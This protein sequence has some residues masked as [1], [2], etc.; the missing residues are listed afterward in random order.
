LTSQ[1]AVLPRILGIAF[2]RLDA[3]VQRLHGAGAA[4]YRGSASVEQGESWL[5]SLACRVAGLPRSGRELPLELSVEMAAPGEIWTRYFSGSAPMVSRVSEHDGRL[6]EQLGPARLVFELSEAQ[7]V[8]HWRGMSLR[9]FGMPVPRWAFDF[10]ARVS[11]GQTHYR[12]SICARM[13]LVGLLIRY[14]GVLHVP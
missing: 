3:P 4:R 8:L 12:F 7:G 1:D 9:V 11:G 5:S 10:R 2:G 6:I 13:A 14:E